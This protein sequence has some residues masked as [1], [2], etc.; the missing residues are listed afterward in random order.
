MEGKMNSRWQSDNPGYDRSEYLPVRWRYT[1]RL[2]RNALIYRTSAMCRERRAPR[3]YVP[4]YIHMYECLHKR[5]CCVSLRTTRVLFMNAYTGWRD[6]T[7]SPLFKD[8]QKRIFFSSWISF[9]FSFHSPFFLPNF[10]FLFFNFPSFLLFFR[11]VHLQPVSSSIVTRRSVPVFPNLRITVINNF[12]IYTR[13]LF[14]AIETSQLGAFSGKEN[15][16]IGKLF[17]HITGYKCEFFTQKFLVFPV[18][19]C[20]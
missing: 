14:T 9:F 8:R 16:R 12:F 15:S 18:I 5:V 17:F 1:H 4:T 11:I 20:Q 3:A 10:S 13:V 6:L 2:H 19:S 7:A